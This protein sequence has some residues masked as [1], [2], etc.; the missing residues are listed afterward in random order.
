MKT[1]ATFRLVES[2]WRPVKDLHD[3]RLAK[4]QLEK[5]RAPLPDLPRSTMQ[6]IAA[7]LAE[8]HP[9]V[10]EDA[11][12]VEAR[13]IVEPFEERRQRDRLRSIEKA[14]KKLLELSEDRE[15]RSELARPVSA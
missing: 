14:E 15:H 10:S 2:V 1:P 12:V 3:Q 4:A 5:A 9:G 7:S 8:Q 13:A 6:A 11:L